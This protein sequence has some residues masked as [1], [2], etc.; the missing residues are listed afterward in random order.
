MQGMPMNYT[1]DKLPEGSMSNFRDI[2][3]VRKHEFPE[4]LVC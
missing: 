1:Q 2:N 3:N 4:V